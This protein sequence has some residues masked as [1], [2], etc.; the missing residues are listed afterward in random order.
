MFTVALSEGLL[1]PLHPLSTFPW[2]VGFVFVTLQGF[3]GLK[4]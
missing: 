1:P 4:Y 3:M 2:A